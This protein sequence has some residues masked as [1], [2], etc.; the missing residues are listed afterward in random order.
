MLRIIHSAL[1]FSLVV[2]VIVS[3]PEAMAV[4]VPKEFTVTTE[5]LLVRQMTFLQVALAGS[6]LASKFVLQLIPKIM[7]CLEI[8]IPVVGTIT[9]TAHEVEK[10]PS[11]EVAVTVAVPTA[12][13]SI[14]PVE[15][16]KT[17][18]ELLDLH[19]T[20]LFVAFE[21]LTWILI[22]SLVFIAN[23]ILSLEGF[24]PVTVIELSFLHEKNTKHIDKIKKIKANTFFFIKK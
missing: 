4:T 24:N 23:V 10:L 1:K 7:Y 18:A 19:V 3:V 21:G 5:G 8:K 20:I 12:R 15:F 16:T 22:E 11:I 2:A 9:L 13:P 14:T 17:M 6:T